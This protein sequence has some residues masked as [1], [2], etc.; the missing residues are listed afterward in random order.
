MPA[1]STDILFRPFRIGSLELPN[2]I[3]MAPM[4]RYFAQGGAPDDAIAAY[5]RRRAEGGVGLILS[6]GAAIDRPGSRYDP[7]VPFFF[8]EAALAGWKFVIDGVHAAGGRMGPQ[9]WHT[10]SRTAPN[11]THWVPDVP[12]ESPSGLTAPGQPRGVTM[13]ERDIA[14]TIAAFASAAADAKRLGFDTVELNG[15]HGYMIDQ[16]FWAAM[17]LRKDG[18][19]GATIGE[20]LRFAIEL[21]H[22]VRAAVGPGFPLILRISQF[23][24]CDIEARVVQSPDEMAEWLQP[25]VAAGVDVIHCSQFRYWDAEFPQIDGP[26]GLSFAGW[27]KKLTG[28]ATIAS[29]AVGLS[30]DFVT[31]LMGEPA[32]GT[33]LD[34]LVARMERDEFDMIAVGRALLND[35]DWVAKARSGRTEE[36]RG[37]S[38]ADLGALA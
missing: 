18:Y 19:G 27:V 14:D 13:T 1:A 3:V 15:A 23:K 12:V 35:P 22:A 5:Y 9:I 7:G 37:F 4:T 10:A 6:E 32:R 24:S 8:G 28:A 2:R 29:G 36:Y 20:R 31:S 38:G 21:V 17:N 26:E 25:L 11:G 33:G 34:P 16:F 30:N